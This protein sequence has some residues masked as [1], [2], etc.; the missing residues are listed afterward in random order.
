MDGELIDVDTVLDDKIKKVEFLKE[1]CTKNFLKI[2]ECVPVGDSN[3]DVGL[4][5]ITGN[6]IVAR[7]EFEAPELEKVAWKKIDHLAELKNIL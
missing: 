7:T 3:N 4:F 5:E 6:G 2:N 1:Y